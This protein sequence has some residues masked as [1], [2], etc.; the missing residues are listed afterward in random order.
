MVDGPPELQN[1]RLIERDGETPARAD[2]MLAAQASRAERL[3]IAD[4]VIENVGTRAELTPE[5]AVDELHHAYLR[6]AGAPRPT[7]LAR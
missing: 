6:R 2:A 1:S 7:G 3:A 5:R 4:D